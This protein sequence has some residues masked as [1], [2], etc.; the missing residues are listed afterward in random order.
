[1]DCCTGLQLA[2]PTAVQQPLGRAK[3]LPELLR[4]N[5]WRASLH[6][7]A[8]VCVP[9]CANL[10]V[11]ARAYAPVC[12][13]V[14]P[15]VTGGSTPKAVAA[16]ATPPPL[17]PEAGVPPFEPMLQRPSANASTGLPFLFVHL[18]KNAGTT[19]RVRVWRHGLCLGFGEM[20]PLTSTIARQSCVVE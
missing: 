4:M 2:P 9:L 13:C 18:P 6:L 19:I 17:D 5:E 8:P 14:R 16:L 15:C 7:Y 20:G 1:V 3:K 11:A 10:C 12:A